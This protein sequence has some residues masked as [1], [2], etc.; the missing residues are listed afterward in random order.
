[1]EK[2]AEELEGLKTEDGPSNKDIYRL[3]CSSFTSVAEE[4][5]KLSTS[6]DGTLKFEE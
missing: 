6:A 5:L 3:N 4:I 1:M 2:L